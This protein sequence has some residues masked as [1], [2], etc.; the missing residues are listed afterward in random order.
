MSL[1]G[2]KNTRPELLLHSHLHRRGLRFRLHEKSLPGTPVL[3]FRR[4]HAV[5]FVNGCFWHWH[6]WSP[7]RRSP[8]QGRPIPPS[9]Q[10]PRHPTSSTNE[11]RYWLHLGIAFTVKPCQPKFYI[12]PSRGLCRRFIHLNPMKRGNRH[13]SPYSS[14]TSAL[15]NGSTNFSRRNP[16]SENEDRYCSN[17]LCMCV[18]VISV[19]C[20]EIANGASTNISFS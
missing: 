17:G 7:C 8:T 19:A 2:Q 5:L 12:P 10:P 18:V 13:G 4:F 14:C 1:V 9:V 20:L 3:V 6:A 11:A 16:F 15:G